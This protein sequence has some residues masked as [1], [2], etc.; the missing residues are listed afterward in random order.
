M[1][2]LLA[3]C[4]S[5]A[6]H[7]PLLDHSRLPEHCFD[8]DAS[9]GK[10]SEWSRTIS[11]RAVRL[12]GT[13]ELIEPRYDAKWAALANV[14]VGGTDDASMVGLR[15]YFSWDPPEM[16]HFVLM[17]SNGPTSGRTVVSVPW[18][19]RA[20]PFTVSLSESRHLTV[21]AGSGSQTLHL[22]DFD[23]QRIA[24]VCSTAEF[25]F[26]AVIVDEQQ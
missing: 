14:F 25:K 9:P 19:H 5:T 11:A 24:L 16:L 20:I 1:A 2:V 17:G 15:A 22:K 6:S 4:A 8:C 13:L 12:S 26:R 10:F 21:S 3:G 7:S 23:V 18:Q